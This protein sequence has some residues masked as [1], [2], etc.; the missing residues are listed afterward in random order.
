MVFF[1]K[2]LTRKISVKPEH[3][4]PALEKFVRDQLTHEV[5]GMPI[6]N[7]GHIITVVSV[8]E[9]TLEKGMIDHLTGNV[10]YN[11]S[12]N[13]LLFRPFKN[14][15]LDATVKAVSDVGF[16]AEAGPLS[17]FVSRVVRVRAAWYW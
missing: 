11:I 13:A 3:L 1:Q 6:D 9:G 8:T 16:F 7:A 10:K 2:Q 5:E 15:V 14:E 4:G 12:F 17:V